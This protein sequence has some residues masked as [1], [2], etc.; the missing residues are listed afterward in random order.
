VT[1]NTHAAAEALAGVPALVV[2]GITGAAVGGSVTPNLIYSA[3]T[4]GT[5]TLSLALATSPFGV[6]LG[7]SSALPTE[8]DLIQVFFVVTAPS[9]I[10]SVEIIFNVGV[11]VDYQTDYYYYDVPLTLLPGLNASAAQVIVQ[12]TFPISSLT[13]VGGDMDRTLA[14]CNGVRVSVVASGNTFVAFGL[15]VAGGGQPD[16]G[17]DGAAYQY[18]A[19]PRSSLTGAQGNATPD[20][21]Y[22]V[23]PHRQNVSIPL[24]AAYDPQ[25][26]TWDVYRY[27]GTITSYRYIGSGAPGSTFI[28]RYFDDTA[29]AGAPVPTQNFEPWPSIDVPY[30]ASSGGGAT[31]TVVGQWVTISGPTS[32]P[33]SI[34]RWLPGTLVL[35]GGQNALTLRAR[36][37]QLSPT[38]YLFEVE[39]CVGAL[40][41][42]VFWVNEPNVA[43]QFAPY[44]WGPDANGFFFAVG[45]QLRPGVVY[46]SGPNSPD[47]VPDTNS[48]E[49]C[50]PSEPLMGG[51][52]L[53]G[54]S[55]VS[56]SARWW[57]MYP[58]FTGATIFAPL[59]K[60]VGR[61]MVAPYGIC[62]DKQRIFFWVKDGI[63]AMAGGNFKSLTDED[64]YPL[65]PHGD[66]AGQ[67]V[68]R[69]GVTYFPPDYSR[70]A[71]FRLAH[72]NGYI[73]AD[74][75]DVIGNHRT[76]VYDIKNDGWSQDT[77][78]NPITTRLS[79]EQ[80]AGTLL[81][82]PSIYPL[83]IMGDA[84]GNILQV[85]DL[86]N[87]A[88]TA[89]SCVVQTFE[90]DGD[91]LR[92][93]ELWGD[94]FVDC[95]PNGN[96]LTISPTSQSIPVAG[97]AA[98][99]VGRSTSRQFVVVS[100]AGGTYLNFIG[101]VLTWT[102]DFTSQLNAT[103]LLAWQPSFSEQVEITTDRR[104]EWDNC[105]TPANK[106]FQ[107]LVIDAD[108]FNLGKPLTIE[109]ADT[110]T[111]HTLQPDPLQHNGRQ[112]LP[113]SFE[114]PF[115]AHAVR[116]VPSDATPWRKFSIVY[117]FEPTP[118]SVR[119]WA[120]QRT[121]HGLTGYQ[122]VMKIE[123]AWAC[124]QP[125]TLTLI[126]AD[127]TSPNAITLPASGGAYVKNLFI[128]TFNKGQ[129]YSY[130]AVSPAPFRLFLNDFVVWVKPWGDPGPY[131]PYRL[132][133]G[134]FGDKAAI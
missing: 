42:T 126:A 120:N 78:G 45:D 109:D 130:S 60:S 76:L 56:S 51:E 122:H 23:L 50:P 72:A 43:R 83:L 110:L 20:M 49:L 86:H 13:R 52:I 3:I 38:E 89:I 90:W 121:A 73:F 119:T 108:T 91:D 35:I 104:G 115:L 77:Y 22:G 114:T 95:I 47:S 112:T 67:E 26:D 129:S 111:P 68:I 116:E 71:S 117:Q 85:Q 31:I 131:T 82:A 21:R 7:A 24:P 102:D 30:T 81:S 118:E 46:F 63:A 61:A 11:T 128:L 36:P 6:P 125:I 106:F 37:I 64:L 15:S 92:I 124:T 79:V 123:A 99:V 33:A 134:A 97:V 80:P 8:D 17:Q 132:L 12:V 87:D 54:L 62:T 93:N 57:A 66:L 44:M 59:E 19:V 69:Q 74:Y 113:Y 48:V 84:N 70:A 103:S 100:T 40:S 39:E 41:P 98:T 2:D 55:Y 27:G 65:F 58:S 127:G 10:T 5:G 88:E 101:M 16:V 105:G 1:V 4:S 96:D 75:E 25:I 34:T 9:L 133:G 107:G 29:S 32:W 94:E 28:D 14:N 18:E 53:Q